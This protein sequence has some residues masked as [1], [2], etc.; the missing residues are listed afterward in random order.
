VPHD[1]Q[2]DPQ[3]S[4]ASSSG[5]GATS[6]PGSKSVTGAPWATGPIPVLSGAGASSHGADAEGAGTAK[7]LTGSSRNGAGANPA[8]E[9]APRGL[10][11]QTGTP[12]PSTPSAPGPAPVAASVAVSAEAMSTKTPPPAG[13]A[14]P[15]GPAR[16]S[17]PA[18]PAAPPA[19]GSPESPVVAAI[20][21]QFPV[22]AGAGRGRH[23]GGA[24][25]AW[26]WV[27][28]WTFLGTLVPGSGLMAAG[29]RR[30]G[31]ALLATTVVLPIFGLALLFQQGALR[32]TVTIGTDRNMLLLLAALVVFVALALTSLMAYTNQ[33][34]MHRAG[35][36]G[37]SRV[38]NGALVVVLAGLI[39]A[40][41]GTGVRY[42]MITRNTLGE[43]F[44]G[45]TTAT[46]PDG[47]SDPWADIPRVNLLMIGSDHDDGRE[48]ARTDSMILASINTKTGDTVLLSPPRNLQRVPFPRD[49]Q[50]YKA[51]PYGFG[52]TRGG[53]WPRGAGACGGACD[54]SAVY[55]WGEDNAKKY[56][57][58]DKN[59]GITAVR[60]AIEGAFGLNVDAH[61][62]VDIDGFKAVVDAL[63]GLTVD[64]KQD[65]PIGGSSEY[66][67]AKEWIRK[68]NNQTLDG[69]HAL[70]FARSRWST[71]DYDRM[72]RQRC[73]I[74]ALTEQADPVSLVRAYPSIAKAAG[75]SITTDIDTDDLSAWVDL[76][77][78]I[79]NAS[80]K[81]L[82]FTDQV[83]NY[84]F[85][86][87]QEIRTLVRDA[88]RTTKTPKDT[89]TSTPTPPA[90]ALGATATPGA[91]ASAGPKSTPKATLD[92]EKAQDVRDVC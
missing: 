20:T 3:A 87:Y 50:A 47:G 53:P 66:P 1:S 64:V 85:P 36:R 42:L 65:L 39:A 22:V 19:G 67:V 38:I 28:G 72:R 43:V 77:L 17:G 8:D 7:N 10:P 78:K 79:K 59:P 71:T 62:V 49:S 70:W 33:Q 30:F 32:T 29:R 81:S 27:A 63:G 4:S 54:L 44:D 40:P 92:P 80:V 23:V 68:G 52:N 15:A 58:G 35:R 14:G 21:G 60:S 13:P 45:S 2:D 41:A 46:K 5:S 76:T 88:I 18:R 74:A 84:A 55:R 69:Y 86:N 31:G 11:V 9:T 91:G 56:Y 6:V 83:V 25:R 26:L 12:S 82:P 16:P 24:S 51:W 73:V 75:D 90:A 48:S 89:A 37:P 61:V 57:R 34:L